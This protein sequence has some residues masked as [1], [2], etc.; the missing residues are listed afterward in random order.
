MTCR[1]AVFLLF[2]LLAATLSAN[3]QQNL[4]NVPSGIITEKGD[5]FFQQQFNLLRHSGVSNTTTGFG[6]GDGWEAGFNVFD[7]TFYDSTPP[8]ASL[9][10]A[11]DS[12]VNFD[13]MFNVQKGFNLTD[14]WHLGIG[15]Q[16]GF[17]PSRRTASMKFQNFSWAINSF[18]IPGP[19]RPW[20]KLFAGAYYSNE[21]YGGFGNRFG[22]MLG[23]EIPIIEHKLAFQADA[24]LGTNDLS[25]IVIG[26]VYEFQCGWQLSL[27]WQ[28]PAPGSSNDQGLVVEFTLPGWP[29]WPRRR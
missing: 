9:Q 29:L 21:H 4:F 18:E 17:N 19:H 10:P 14:W 16:A 11:E 6:L 1:N 22:A 28:L 3:A 7:F 20:G 5:L 2:V 25:V 23:T 26:G 15:T 8:P 13:L 24:L 27:G 12:Q